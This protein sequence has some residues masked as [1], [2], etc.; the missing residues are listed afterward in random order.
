LLRRDRQRARH[1][2]RLGRRRRQA[3]ISQTRSTSP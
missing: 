1:H 2:N 3:G